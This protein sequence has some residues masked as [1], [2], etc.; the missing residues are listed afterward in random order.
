MT[1]RACVV[2]WPVK[3]SRSPVIHRF[4]LKEYGID[5]DYVIEPVEP[6]RIAAFFEKFADSGFVGCNVTV[7]HK[8]AAFAAVAEMDKAAREIGALNTIW[9]DGRRLVGANTDAPG[10]LASLDQEIPGWSAEAGPAVVLGAGGAARAIVWAL[11]ERGFARITI[12]NRTPDR[13]A[14]LAASFGDKVATAGWD[15]LPGL[16]C[17][18][19]LLVNTTTLGMEGQPPLEVDLAPLPADA[20]VSDLIYVPLETPLVAAAKA[21]G[22]RAGGG[23]GMLLHQAVPGFAHWFGTRPVV[24]PGLRDAVVAT[25]KPA[26]A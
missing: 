9:L 6:E 12:V 7:P 17:D 15:E 2:G 16:L 14:A 3:H 18:A 4:W 26:A 23:L 20:A 24:T 19:R 11:K 13:T 1:R 21:R 22:L 5:G 8:E 25:L 10:F